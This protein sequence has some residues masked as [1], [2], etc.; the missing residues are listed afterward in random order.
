MDDF[1]ELGRDEKRKEKRREGTS[2][3]RRMSGCAENI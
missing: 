1:K 3:K 2:E